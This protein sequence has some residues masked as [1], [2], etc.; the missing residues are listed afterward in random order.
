[1]FI[2]VSL[3]ASTDDKSKA[4]Y[5]KAITK[6]ARKLFNKFIEGKHSNN[7]YKATFDKAM[8]VSKKHKF[9]EI[10]G[11]SRGLEIYNLTS[12]NFFTA[13]RRAYYTKKPLLMYLYLNTCGFCGLYKKYLRGEGR[14]LAS[15]FIIVAVDKTKF[16]NVMS[17]GNKG[18]PFT[19]VYNVETG[20]GVY[21]F[22]GYSYDG[23]PKNLKYALKRH[24]FLRK[25]DSDKKLG[26]KEIRER[27][28]TKEAKY[29]LTKKMEISW[30]L[31]RAMEVS[32]KHKF[33]VIKGKS[34]GLEIYDLATTNFF[35]AFR[36]AYQSKKPLLLFHYHV[37]CNACKSY[38]K[39]LKSM[40]KELASKF[41]IVAI[42]KKKFPMVLSPTK[43]GTPYTKVFTEKWKSVLVFP[44]YSYKHAQ[45]NLKLALVRYGLITQEKD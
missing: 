10:S 45:K 29:W 15:K 24:A 16:S 14:K 44:G 20:D 11:K 26:V 23:V 27:E 7:S 31:Q 19:R 41:I 28:I 22:S 42:D 2:S 35:T 36:R 32:E 43:V 37:A 1:M 30:T 8:E 9:Q 18:V 4:K 33:K 21:A 25:I 34:T 40:G 39:Y 13:F 3:N 5:E 38:K 6:E 17:P 12:A